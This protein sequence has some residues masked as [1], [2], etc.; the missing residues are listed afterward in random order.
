MLLVV[1]SIIQAHIVAWI[2][3]TSYKDYLTW[4][5]SREKEMTKIINSVIKADILHSLGMNE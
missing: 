1:L 4:L 3:I 5:Q 2:I